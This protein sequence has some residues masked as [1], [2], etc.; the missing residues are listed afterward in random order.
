MRVGVYVYVLSFHVKDSHKRT[1]TM[2]EVVLFT[3]DIA[4]TEYK[5]PFRSL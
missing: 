4:L 5:R 1:A 3:P 2:L